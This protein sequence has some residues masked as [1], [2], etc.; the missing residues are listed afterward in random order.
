MATRA[1]LLPAM[2]LVAVDALVAVD[3]LPV[4]AGF[5]GDRVNGL[6]AATFGC[7]DFLLTVAVFATGLPAFFTG[8]AAGP[9][10]FAT[11]IPVPVF[12]SMRDA[13]F[14][15]AP[16][17]LDTRQKSY[18]SA[19]AYGCRYLSDCFLKSTKNRL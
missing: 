19:L 15:L 12:C 10:R 18:I 13:I 7:L 14:A 11:F 17:K 9:L 8:F 1:T 2:D 6:T 3:P 4:A 5:A 16:A